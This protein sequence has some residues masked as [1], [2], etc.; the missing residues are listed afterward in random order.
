MAG[1][2]VTATDMYVL[3]N[4]CQQQFLQFTPSVP[5]VYASSNF[6]DAKIAV[7][8]AATLAAPAVSLAILHKWDHQQLRG[9]VHTHSHSNAIG[10]MH[11]R[12]PLYP[13]SF[14][15][16]GLQRCSK[17]LYAYYVRSSMIKL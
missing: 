5:P 10:I 16:S 13:G 8:P 12:D 15:S 9:K 4:V 1:G 6:S 11:I 14:L 3:V 17:L 7:S 2:S